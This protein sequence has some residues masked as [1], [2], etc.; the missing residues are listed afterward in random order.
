MPVNNFIAHF[1]KQIDIRR[2]DDDI[3]ILPTINTVD[4]YRYSDG[5]FKHMPDDALKTYGDTLL[6]SK[7]AVK[8][9]STAERHPNNTDN[10]RTDNN[11]DY[12]IDTFHD[13]ITF[14]NTFNIFN[15]F[16]SSKFSDI[17]RHKIYFYLRARFKQVV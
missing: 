1:I 4:I 16:R 5:M 8:L 17:F 10:S 2:Y 13:Y 15:R 6:Y 7:K 3:K 9:A 12:R 14:Q 11:L